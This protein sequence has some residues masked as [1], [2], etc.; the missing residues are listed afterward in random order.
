[1]VAKEQNTMVIMTH[2]FIVVVDLEALSEGTC[3]S[4]FALDGVPCHVYGSRGYQ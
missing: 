2:G 1:M 4:E 3:D